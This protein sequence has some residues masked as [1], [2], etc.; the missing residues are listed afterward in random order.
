MLAELRAY[1]GRIRLATFIG[2]TRHQ[3]ANRY[4]DEAT[5]VFANLGSLLMGRTTCPRWAETWLREAKYEALAGL[6]ASLT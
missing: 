3:N 1:D 2:G 5:G 4:N 6:S